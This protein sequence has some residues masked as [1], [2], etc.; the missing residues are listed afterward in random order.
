MFEREARE[1]QSYSSNTS[2]IVVSL[3]RITVHSRITNIVCITLKIVVKYT[4][5]LRNTKLALRART[6]VQVMR[7]IS[8]NSRRVAVV[9]SWYKW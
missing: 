5:M 9:N 6:Q 1:F 3:I 4:R 2:N 8:K 7:S